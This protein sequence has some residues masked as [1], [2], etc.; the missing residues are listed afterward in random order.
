MLSRDSNN[1]PLKSEGE[2]QNQSSSLPAG[3]DPK[4]SPSKDEKPIQPLRESQ[5]AQL[6][7]PQKQDATAK[8]DVKGKKAGALK[9]LKGRFPTVNPFKGRVR[10]TPMNKNEEQTP[11]EQPPAQ[12][13]CA[14]VKQD[15][16]SVCAG[17]GTRQA[18]KDELLSVIN[19]QKILVSEGY[20]AQKFAFK[21]KI[22]KSKEV[23][24]KLLEKQ[25]ET[26]GKKDY[27]ICW[28]KSKKSFSILTELKTIIRGWE[29]APVLKRNQD[30]LLQ[31]SNA[32]R[33]GLKKHC[34]S[35]H[36]GDRSLNLV[37]KDVQKA[38][39]LENFVNYVRANGCL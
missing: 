30:K 11:Q 4:T 5:Q 33:F 10:V 21:P 9:R 13:V 23:C 22:K 6:G 16:S 38:D 17:G 39:S 20:V 2:E 35:F 8:P 27:H 29:D 36:F 14:K 3:G 1:A 15:D 12:E 18:T 28:S 24:I 19:T 31:Y 34:L 37:F 7:E 32:G 25:D 26:T